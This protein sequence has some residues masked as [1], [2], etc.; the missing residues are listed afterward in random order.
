MSITHPPYVSPWR[1]L[2]RSAAAPESSSRPIGGGLR[3]SAAVFLL[4]FPLLLLADRAAAQP[5]ITISAD[6][7]RV[8]E[9]TDAIFRIEASQAPTAHLT[10][11]VEVADS[12]SF[13]SSDGIGTG[14]EEVLLLKGHTALTLAVSTTDDNRA[15][16]HGTI[17]VTVRPGS[18]TVGTPSEAVVRVSDNDITAD[19][20][21]LGAT[22]LS[23]GG[24]FYFSI[25]LSK[26]LDGN[27]TVTL[28]LAI[29]GTATRGTDYRLVCETSTLATCNGIDGAT[30][31][32]TFHGEELNKRA[33]SAAQNV[34]SVVWFEA[35]EDNTAESN[36][37]VT[38]SLGGRSTTITL[39]DA[40][41]S[42]TLAFR[43]GNYSTSE[44][45][46]ALEPTLVV[47]TAPG[48]NITV[49]LV[50]T[51]I[52]AT[53]GEDYLVQLG[54][55]DDTF[56]ANGST[57]QAINIPVVDDNVVEE[58]ETYR[59]EID[60]S[61]LPSWVTV[62]S[63]ASAVMTIV[64]NDRVVTIS[65]NRARVTEGTSAEFTVS[66]SPAP[67]QPFDVTVQV[68]DS[69]NFAAS[70]TGFQ[71]V[72]VGTDGSGTLTVTTTDDN[73][74]EAHGTLTATV[75]FG[76]GNYTI[77]T[78]SEAVVRVS[79][80]DITVDT[81]AL[82]GATP[83]PEG[84]RIL[85]NTVLSKPPDGDQTLTLPLTFS[86]TATRG[87]D[88]RLACEPS[89]TVICNELNGATPSLTFDGERL[90][91]Q[92]NP[93]RSSPI[94][95]EA[96]EDDTAESNE[97]AILSLGGRSAT[98][99]LK[100][101]PSSVT[102][103]FIQA[104]KAFSETINLEVTLE[105]DPAPG[106]EIVVPLVYTDITATEGEDYEAVAT[107]TFPANGRTRNAARPVIPVPDDDVY[108]GDETFR[109]EIDASKLPDWVT[110]GSQASQ[111]VTIEDNEQPVATISPDTVRV[112][113]GTAAEFTVSMSPAP[114]QPLEVTVEVT[115]SG[116]FAASGTGTQQVT[117]GT[118]GSG[119]LTVTT[120]DDNTAEAHGTLTATVQFGSG[121]Y[122]I[123]TPSEAVVRVSDDDITADLIMLGGTPLSEGGRFAFSL[124]LSKAL[125]GDQTLTLPLALGGTATRGTDYRL[126][127]GE[128]TT[129]ITCNGINGATPSLTFHGEGFNKRSS[130]NTARLGN[131]LWFE[132][133]E[134][135]T[136]ES[137][138]TVTL[139][140]GGRSVTV[141]LQ[142]APSSVTLAFRQ[143]NYSAYENGRFLQPTLEV[144]A[145]PGQDITVPLIFNNITATEGRDYKAVATVTFPANGNTV[146]SFD[147]ALLD[148]NVYEGDETFLLRID[149]SK[150]PSWVTV[151]SQGS[152]VATIRDNEQPIVTIS[153]DTARVTEG[154]SA[155]FTV[156]TSPAPPQSFTVTVEV[157]DS[158]NFAASG[159]G[160]QQVT[161]GTDGSGT[162]TVT[163]TD[164]NT[165]E[166]HGT[167][168]ATLS[169]GAYDIGTPS[170]AVVRVSDND[171]TANLVILGGTPLSEGGRFYFNV[172][173]SKALDGDQ[174]LTLPLALGGTATRGTDYRLV[175]E[176]ST[177][178][179]CNGINGAT[180]SITF[181]GEE[182][183]KRG[184]GLDFRDDTVVW[185]E[186][187]EDD[188]AESNE[189]VTLSLGG[190]S[191]TITLQ[192][193]PSSVTLAFFRDNYS[194]SERNLAHEPTLVVDTA[195]GQNITVPLVF[196]AI[197]ATEG[198]DY[199][200]VA[201]VTFSANGRT[202]Q[203]IEIP[204]VD[205]NV[206]EEDETYRVEID[207]S[208]LPGWVTVGSQASA[209]M[210][211]VDNDR[212]V[213]ISANRARVTEGTSAEFTVSAS[214]APTQPF[215]V[216]VQVTDSGNFAASGTGF[217]EVTVGTDGSGTLTVTTTDDNTAEAHGTLTATVQFG[218][219]NY[220]IG[221]PS[222]AVVRV[223]DNDITVRTIAFFGTTPLPE[224][225]RFLVSIRLSKALDGD[226]TLTLP[227]TFSGTATRGTDY[228]LVCGA[229][230]TVICNGLNG[231]TPS[232]TF[233]GEALSK[234][235]SISTRSAPI[236]FEAIEDDTAESNETATL[237]LGGR[238][239]TITI[240]DA[241]SSVTLA[242][243]AASRS[244]SEATEFEVILEVDAAPGQE[245]VVP[246]VFT[247]ITATEGEDYEAVATTTFPANGRTRDAAEPTIPFLD[248]DVY[249]GDETFRMEIDA[250]KLPDWVTVGSQASQV[251]TITDNENAPQVSFDSGTY[252][253]T[254]GGQVSITV[255]IDVARP[256]AT[257]VPISY[258]AVSAS[259]SHTDSLT[260]AS[261]LL[262]NYG[263]DYEAGPAEV[264][265][266][267]EAGG[268]HTFTVQTVDDS[269]TVVE[270]EEN[271][272]FRVTLG[273]LPEGFERG[274]PSTATV[275]IMDDEDGF[276]PVLTSRGGNLLSEGGRLPLTIVLGRPLD[277]DYRLLLPLVV[278]G[279]ATRG[280]DYR[281][282]CN[283]A[284]RVASC[285]D[286]DGASPSIIFDGAELNKRRL[287]R[288]RERV[289][290]LLSVEVIEDNTA[291]SNETIT[292]SLGGGQVRRLT[293]RDAPS[294]VTLSFFLDNY[295]VLRESILL[296]PSLRV[297]IPPGQDIV[298]PLVFT[299]ITAT[300]GEDYEA[301]ATVTFP[302][303]SSTVES[304]DI[305]ILDDNVYEGD[306][307]FRITIDA[308]RLPS[309]VK[310]GSQAS[311]V[312]TI[313]DDERPQVSFDSGTYRVIEGGQVSITVS[314]DVE[315][316]TATTVPIS[317]TDVSAV[318]SHSSFDSQ[319]RVA[320]GQDYE[321]SPAEVVIPAEAGGSH[322]FTVQTVD[323]SATVVQKEAN[324]TFR[325]SLGELP[326]GIG[327]GSPSTATVTIVD[328]DVRDPAPWVSSIER[329]LPSVS[330]TA[331]DSLTWEVTFSEDVRNVDKSDFRLSGTTATLSTSSTGRPS[332]Y[333]VVASGGDLADLN[334]TVVLGFASNQNIEDSKGNRLVNTRPI[335]A[336][337]DHFV[338][339]N[340]VAPTVIIT[341][342][343]AITKGGNA[344]FTLTANPA[345]PSPLTVMVTVTQRG[346]V[347]ASDN[348]LG[349]Q[350]VIIPPGGS[351][352][353]TVATEDDTRLKGNG[354][355]TVT[356]D[357]SINYTVGNPSSAS[358]TVNDNDGTSPPPPPPTTPT[359]TI[360]GG[361]PNPVTEGAGANFT[362]T[363]TPPPLSPL[364]VTVTVTQ[365]G[366]FVA[367]GNLNF[368]TVTI[369]PSGSMTHT[370]ATM[371]DNIPEANG[372]VRVT[373]S[374]GAGYTV[375]SLA[376]AAVRVNDDD[377]TSP[378]PTAPT[379][380]IMGG[381]SP[382]TEGT[383]A[384]F[385]VS[386]SGPV[387]A[388]LPVLLRVRETTTGGQDFVATA[389]EGVKTVTIPSGAA[390]ALYTVTTVDDN[391]AE[392]DGMVTVTLNSSSA[393][394][395]GS[396]F[397]AAVNVS[398]DD[399][400]FLAPP[401]VIPVVSITGGGG[402]TEGQAAT[403]TVTAVPTPPPGEPISV[404]VAISDSGNFVA[405]G[406][407]GSRSVTID[408]SGMARFTVST[409]NDPLH[410]DHG[411]ITATVEGGSGYTPHASNGSASVR[412]ED[413]DPA[414]MLSVS[415]LKVTEGGSAS[416]TIALDT[417]PTGNVTVAISG[418]AATDL[419]LTPT[420]L[421]FTPSNWD[422]PQ[423]VTI[424]APKDTDFIGAAITLTHTASGLNY[425]GITAT[426]TATVVAAH[427]T[428][429]AKAWQLRLGRT[430]SHQVMDALEDRLSA[431]PATGLQL[432]VAGEAIVSAPP[433]AEHEGLLSKALGFDP[434]TAQALAEDSSFSFA[435]EQEGAA[436]RLAFWGQGAFS[437]F[438]G[439]EEEFSLDGS[440]TTLLLGADWSRQRWQAG[441]AL[442][443]SWGN[444]SYEGDNSSE[445][446][447]TSTVTGLFP[448]GRYAL[449]PRLGLW[450]VAGYGWGQLSLKPDGT[451]DDATPS[452][453]MTMA[454]LGMDGLLFD[455]G[456]EGI[457][458]SSTA[459]VLTLKTTSEEVDGLES[460]EGSL[461][462]LR[463]GIEAVRPFPLS[464]GASLLPSLALGIRQD[465]GDAETGFGLDL[466]AG[467]L[468]QAPERG[469]S[470][471]L[472]GHT[473]LAH[474]EEDLQEQGLALSF[475]WEPTPSKRGPSLSLSHAMGA[476]AAGGMDALLNPT[477]FE[478]LDADPS[479]GQRFEAEL[480]YGFPAHN[481]QLTL[482]PA[483]ALALS[484]TSRNYSLL[485]SLVPYTD[486]AQADPWQLSLAGERQEPNAAPSP[487]D[488]SLKLHF[489]TLF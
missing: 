210:T 291:E 464:N 261:N 197:T 11:S 489:S 17:T 459:D 350:T 450:A 330:P 354:R 144:D 81:I 181:D 225:G 438:R 422:R 284:S 187:I 133:I 85:L 477:T 166:A 34:S 333:E 331:F 78:P 482:T 370:V 417:R 117:V 406:Q 6:T 33:R 360:R 19:V 143:A 39:Q 463:L 346:N 452:T 400:D 110:L 84:G 68:T 342:G 3:W 471:A 262:I 99:T 236:W 338:V 289:N 158:G 108:E 347:V 381:P 50:F 344:V 31:S 296:Q 380:T 213:T 369:P 142:D 252:S 29:G 418:D 232:L 230:T 97:T 170:E 266:P 396:P 54:E 94:W 388:P 63:Q 316:P 434:L 92:N 465:S 378:P 165:E 233:D 123:G 196:T 164:D 403:F 318:S 382:I 120:T 8:T 162:L 231:A 272:T 313:M 40:P 127:C 44:R 141:T 348:L 345:P 223:S 73:T 319:R 320:F 467:I 287:I 455:G 168:T 203:G 274:T 216:T 7:A 457:T 420:S 399:G 303:S 107:V 309:W 460:S 451:G 35:I 269:A 466:G 299:D 183:N 312:M 229:S 443:Q 175:C 416:Y 271:E 290:D 394:L 28:P 288:N 9:G 220:T 122:T 322:T 412:V 65:A 222:E 428:E 206:V 204:L 398:D 276:S 47:D 150:L 273:A 361:N 326:A 98:I 282:V 80:N 124:S 205:D 425:A 112:T 437:S 23:E 191:L 49:P 339:E 95:F 458:L 470:G 189:T 53:E 22:P 139:S 254:E 484:P 402:I 1:W 157:T 281:L 258:T 180:P 376:S 4:G 480:A 479:S 169:S 297:D 430:V 202:V 308:S 199:E 51:A 194:T 439:E 88:Y 119:T 218:S 192:D 456:N 25:R 485:W 137:N 89:T 337:E 24:R 12:G 411:R 18:Y 444:G 250:S 57:V 327:K 307:T 279:T 314:I 16:A 126:V 79:D 96:I 239:A 268:S 311:A 462:R 75:Q 70:G 198:E 186:A 207:A 357:Q 386:R 121:N 163:T 429:E 349:S 251:V 393:Y 391:T 481:D 328:D 66:A 219:G 149:T 385:T 453:T 45:S 114:V 208:K 242:F 111:V 21:L 293:L 209:V 147:I 173:L 427:P 128:F 15:E 436:P 64:D 116:S 305:N 476:T 129:L 152:A 182:L 365:T 106:Q 174:T 352:T 286:M 415:R 13:V 245:I 55:G 38:L 42:V 224:G 329:S 62:G 212:V 20:F 244:L 118:D 401:A 442:S 115:D 265:I 217:Q 295:F 61:K 69:G 238:S 301:V 167:I 409:Q 445:G 90:N 475:S 359:I 280:T 304:F 423:R 148:D 171:I 72:T 105:V 292:L 136:A 200:V 387:T 362:V 353:H 324:E 335:G 246:L 56:Y 58:D 323:D 468:W 76:S 32:I 419:T 483:V 373:V 103:G 306:E 310:V 151:G 140:L 384:A 59:V 67:T 355:V 146:N 321:A 201:T 341:G 159:T 179:I 317:Y 379:V 257:T 377:G 374:Q 109:I 410:E 389:L 102:L 407:S 421:T 234:Q 190:R 294:S 469:I 87:T 275:T 478:G 340:T 185:F 486:Q 240:Q 383:A 221:T 285:N 300:E 104:S 188:T 83:L 334:G 424:T 267:A 60:A 184:S 155:E 364:N 259:S 243:P 91:K 390:T 431:R 193:A 488:H 154:T 48:Q 487:V 336:N 5:V 253:V 237:S 86:G 43:Q 227:L 215:D 135:D 36:E 161:V 26:A 435:P 356:V 247:D 473:L 404:N 46:E 351:V 241:P 395:V 172:V 414:L 10:L 302:A 472:K 392:P 255:S 277:G 454:A 278:G 256:T 408:A 343:H 368:Q 358:V 177:A 249:E 178:L 195:P 160:T 371:N 248:D 176:A 101:A 130:I 52:T 405:T 449:T 113:E 283:R 448:Y 461:S 134:D 153:A 375:G 474:G 446:E 432:T 82:N 131:A 156:S 214:P 74:A 228:R 433:L 77:G 270:V 447:I 363:A 37:T 138:E 30:P 367:S 125:D 145:A 93:T 366:D 100:D 441:A 27:Q 2:R 413:D 41:S 71:E 332:L 14:T 235:G 440:V 132:A 298:V 372:L 426:V 397:A 260:T 226:Q 325:V 315:R 264:V 211:I 263:K